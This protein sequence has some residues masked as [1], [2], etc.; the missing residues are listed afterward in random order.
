MHRFE[1]KEDFLLDGKPYKIMSGAIHYFRIRPQ[2]WYHSLYNLKALGCN[3]VETYIPWNLH[4]QE[5]GT[6]DFTEQL[7]IQKFTY[8]AQELGLFVV[9]R[10]SPYIC[11]EW[12]FG[13]LPAWLLNDRGGMRIRSSDP[14]FIEKVASYYEKLFKQISPLQIDQGGPVIMMQLENEYGSYGEDKEYLSALYELMI[15][16]NVTVPLFTS[17]GAWD[18]AQTAGMLLEKNILSTGNFGSKAQE[19]FAVLK[20]YINVMGKTG[21]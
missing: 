10:P 4:E 2:E 9:L 3:T 12:E 6:F 13:G 18:E 7:D 15:K 16:N 11:A 14:K 21:R 20:I 8:L 1:V 5:E 19:N 17:D